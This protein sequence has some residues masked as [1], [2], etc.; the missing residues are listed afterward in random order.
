M[1][2]QRALAEVVPAGLALVPNARAAIMLL[3]LRAVGAGCAPLE[4]GAGFCPVGAR[5]VVLRSAHLVSIMLDLGGVHQRALG[6]L[7]HGERGLAESESPRPPDHLKGV[8]ERTAPHP[9][10]DR[11]QMTKPLRRRSVG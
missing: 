2:V 6:L 5:L 10:S 11:S 8:P 4:A 3:L 7:P 1:G 9:V